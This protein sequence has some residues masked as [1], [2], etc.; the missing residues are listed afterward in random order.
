MKTATVYYS[1]PKNRELVKSKYNRLSRIGEP[2]GAF[3]ISEGRNKG[4]VSSHEVDGSRTSHEVAPR[5]VQH[6]GWFVD[7]SEDET[8]CGIVVTV[9]IP[10]R[11]A[12]LDKVAADENGTFTRVRFVEGIRD[13]SGNDIVSR[14]SR[15]LHDDERDAAVSAD[16]EAKYHAE[17]C[18]EYDAE[19]Q[20]E[21]EI[22]E[23]RGE[24]KAARVEVL[25]ILHE[26]KTIN[27]TNLFHETPFRGEV[28]AVCRAI[29]SQVSALLA[30]VAELRA[31]IDTLESDYWAAVR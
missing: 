24:I 11:R 21:M 22:E 13:T 15:D 5:A 31:R 3:T 2:S 17:E 20:A 14:L 19:Y 25:A 12:R 16:S 30:R 6:T 9:R 26:R 7:S 1:N 29:R 23:A 8:A 27:Q 4:W 28:P 18:R 10:R